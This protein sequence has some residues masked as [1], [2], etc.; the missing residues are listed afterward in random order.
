MRTIFNMLGPLTNPAGADVQ[1]MGVY[2]PDLVEPVGQT[3]AR[4]GVESAYVVHGSGGYDEITITGPTRAARVN[5]GRVTLEEIDPQALGMDLAASDAIKGGDAA[6]NAG[7][8]L[9]VLKGEEGAPRDMVLLNA[10]AA[11]HAAGKAADLAGGV[12]LAAEAIDSGAALAKLNQL[13][14]MTADT[15][16]E[17][18][19]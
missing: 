12:A 2:D 1:I 13:Q 15:P 17:A 5:G 16:Q 19:A 3:L 7:I 11:I 6:F 18:I 14:A 10:G 9:A 8:T 4:L